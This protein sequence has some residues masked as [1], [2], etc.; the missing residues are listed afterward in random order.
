[1]NVKEVD[2]ILNQVNIFEVI[3]NFINLTKKGNDFLGLC[4]FH[5][6]SSPSLSVSVSKKIFKCFSCNVGG[7]AYYFVKKFN[8]WDDIKTLE[9]FKNQFNL[10]IDLSHIQNNIKHYS[11]NELQALKA[12]DDAFLFY[13]LELKQNSPDYVKKFLLERNLNKEI[14]DFFSIGY[15]P[16]SGIKDKLLK[17][18]HDEALLINYSLISLEKKVDIF[19]D[20]L[21]FAIKNLDNKVIGFSGRKIL[22]STLGPKYLNSS[23]NSLFSKSEVLYNYSNAV[24]F[25]S[26]SKTLIICEGFMDVI[27]FYKDGIKNAIAI[28]GTALTK[29]HIQHL[30]P[31]EILLV[32]DSDQ[33]GI[34]ATLKSIYTLLEHKITTKVLQPLST[35]DP[36]EYFSKFGPGS[37]QKA[38]KNRQDGINFVYEHLSKT[39]DLNNLSSL[40]HFIK[41]FSKY[42][43]FCTKNIQD[44]FIE[45]I[46]KDFNISPTSWKFLKTNSEKQQRYFNNHYIKELPKYHKDQVTPIYKDDLENLG[47]ELAEPK[48]QEQKKPTNKPKKEFQMENSEKIALISLLLFPSFIQVIKKYNYEFQSPKFKMYFAKLVSSNFKQENIETIYFKLTSSTVKTGERVKLENTQDKFENLIKTLQNKQ[49]NRN[50]ESILASWKNGMMTEQEAKDAISIIQQRNKQKNEIY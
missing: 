47:V 40:D 28:M 33:A 34:E 15:C 9:Y 30:K 19:Q 41:E 31:Y 17:K 16:K 50:I 21:V 45:K 22:D 38:I 13:S 37:L 8:H 2:L 11:E 1:M 29:N 46:N 39:I 44:F 6:D 26:F 25:A 43:Q 32:L 23:T 3:S 5:E 12:L 49:E 10:N 18:G 27:A 48:I 7:N 20:R 36:D 4:P 42:L 35:K 14:I 24:Q